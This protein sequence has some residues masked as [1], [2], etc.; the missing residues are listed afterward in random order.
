MTLAPLDPASAA[1]PTTAASF[2]IA[3]DLWAALTSTS[4]FDQAK[5]FLALFGIIA[6][7]Y[8]ALRFAAPRAAESD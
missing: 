4:L 8:H 7:T 1:E 6:F 2:P 5:T 3:V